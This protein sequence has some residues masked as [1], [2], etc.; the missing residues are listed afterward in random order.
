MTTIPA[1]DGYHALHVSRNH[2]AGPTPNVARLTATEHLPE[3]PHTVVATKLLLTHGAHL[4]VQPDADTYRLPSATR[5]PRE[6]PSRTIHRLLAELAVTD[7]EPELVG[8]LNVRPLG[9]TRNRRATVQLYYRAET[10]HTDV[11]G[12]WV[13]P[14]QVPTL[15]TD[16]LWYPL[17]CH[18]RER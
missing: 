5:E 16:A 13:D 1:I 14:D 9:G 18:L 3:Q 6:T 15:A 2:P 17:F 4:L 8:N 11:A 12:H 7:G 10:D